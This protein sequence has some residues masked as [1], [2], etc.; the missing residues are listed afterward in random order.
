MYRNSIFNPPDKLS[1]LRREE[2]DN[3]KE[4][5]NNARHACNSLPKKDYIKYHSTSLDLHKK[6]ESK[7][8]ELYDVEEKI[9]D[10]QIK[11]NKL[12]ESIVSLENQLKELEESFMK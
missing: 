11:Q 8:S 9:C 10:Y 12:K 4:K 2:E 1:E 5:Q 6:L 7:K 3:E